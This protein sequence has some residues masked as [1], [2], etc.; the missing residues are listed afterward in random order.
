MTYCEYTID[1]YYDNYN[2]NVHESKITKERKNIPICNNITRK[3]D[4]Y[5]IFLLN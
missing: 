4:K 3:N 5:H 1:A 2:L